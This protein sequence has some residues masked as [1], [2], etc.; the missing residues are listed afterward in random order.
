MQ[1]TQREGGRLV[2]TGHMASPADE[3][4]RTKNRRVGRYAMRTAR[5]GALG[6][7]PQTKRMSAKCCP[8]ISP[9]RS[10]PS[11]SQATIMRSRRCSPSPAA[12]PAAVPRP[13]VMRIPHDAGAAGDDADID[14]IRAGRRDHD[15]RPA[16]RQ[17][18]DT[19]HNVWPISAVPARTEIRT[20]E[21]RPIRSPH[22]SD[23]HRT[24]V[25]A[26][27]EHRRST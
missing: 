4:Q 18:E 12:G 27:D 13:T 17:S 23:E 7:L 16:H 3:T 9:M 6:D 20:G 2:P 5:P 8:H 15:G 11:Y 24:Q 25:S 10:P 26:S 22:P 14:A 1:L 21:D 19:R